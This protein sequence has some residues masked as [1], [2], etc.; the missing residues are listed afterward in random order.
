MDLTAAA[1]HATSPMNGVVRRI[2]TRPLPLGVVV[3]SRD[4]FEGVLGLGKNAARG[5]L[6]GLFIAV[7]LHGSAAARAA[8]IPVELNAWTHRIAAAISARLVETYEVDVAKAPP[9]PPPPPEETKPEPKEAPPVV[10]EAKERPLDVAPAAAKASAVLTQQEDPN[11]PVDLTNSFV[12]GASDS[13]AGGVTQQGGTS[14]SAVYNRNAIAAGVPG[15]TGKAPA[16]PPG[17]DR[18]RPAGLAG[19]KEWRCPWPAE[20]EVEQIDEAFV[21]VQVTTRADGAADKVAVL[22]DP[23]HGFAREAKMCA[24]RERYQPALDRDGNPIPGLT[25]SIRIRFER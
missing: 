24:M 2:S 1:P 14:N 8:L 21:V 23:G 16:P 7:V 13:F 3:P 9:P 19:S 12:V 25:K 18:S 5:A 22:S 6:L 11:Q 4:P 17:P 20:A 10:K 15:G